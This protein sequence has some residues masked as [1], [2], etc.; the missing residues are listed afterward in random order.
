MIN[1][2]VIIKN[3]CKN[4]NLLYNIT[5]YLRIKIDKNTKIHQILNEISDHLYIPIS[6]QGAFCIV[7]PWL[8]TLLSKLSFVIA[9]ISITNVCNISLFHIWTANDTD[10]LDSKMTQLSQNRLGWHR[11]DS[12]RIKYESTESFLSQLSLYNGGV[13]HKTVSFVS[14]AN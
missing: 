1:R 4:V 11:N 12:N 10:S 14:P 2:T 8:Y 7:H 9:T 3:W 13:W 6:A 5:R